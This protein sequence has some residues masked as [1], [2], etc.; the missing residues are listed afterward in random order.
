M[1]DNE[2]VKT[3]GVTKEALASSNQAFAD[4]NTQVD[5]A[6][7]KVDQAQHQ[8]NDAKAKAAEVGNLAS[9]LGSKNKTDTHT[10]AIPS[11][12]KPSAP[13]VVY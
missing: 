4:L 5:Q 10:P 6:K 9:K 2:V 8:L 7:A 3:F 11:A 12:Y 1:S 13:V